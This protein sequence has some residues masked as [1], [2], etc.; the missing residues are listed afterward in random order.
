MTKPPTEKTIDPMIPKKPM[1]IYKP[2]EVA[3][4]KAPTEKT[5]DP[6]LAAPPIIPRTIAPM[7]VAVDPTVA[8]TK[9]PTEKTI[10]P[11]E[12]V[13]APTDPEPLKP[14]TEAPDL[15][16]PPIIARPAPIKVH[17]DLTVAMTKAPTEK[18]IDPMEPVG[19]PEFKPQT[20]P[21]KV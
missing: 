11:M 2:A 10:D 15:T 1:A 4:K 5:I 7:K 21:F 18:T 9:A 12:P 16:A 20:R 19:V 14:K 3:M 6:Y 8:M 13:E 17:K